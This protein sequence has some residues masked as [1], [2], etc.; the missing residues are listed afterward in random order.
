MTLTPAQVAAEEYKNYS[1]LTNDF[2]WL[3]D[4]SCEVVPLTYWD[5][6]SY[7]RYQSDDSQANLD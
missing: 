2:R 7:A 6:A 5:D 3:P 1:P 4:G